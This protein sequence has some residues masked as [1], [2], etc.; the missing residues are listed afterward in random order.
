MPR[1]TSGPGHRRQ[2]SRGEPKSQSY[3]PKSKPEKP[4]FMSEDD[5]EP[6]VPTKDHL[7][8]YVM[9]DNQA[10]IKM[11]QK[12]RSSQLGHVARRH[13]V[14]LGWVH[15]VA[16]SS[17]EDV[18]VISAQTD[19]QAADVFTQSF[20]DINKWSAAV[21]NVGLRQVRAQALLSCACICM[22]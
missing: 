10:T 18:R 19:K 3:Y 9:E 15:E 14:S 2:S 6:E 12:G 1:E 22:T 20:T 16:T 21:N 4:K 13:R 17:T 5:T 11:V 7:R 8:V